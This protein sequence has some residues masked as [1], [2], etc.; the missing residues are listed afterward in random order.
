MSEPKVLSD[1]D[2]VRMLRSDDGAEVTKALDELYGPKSAVL[3]VAEVGGQAT[4]YPTKTVNLPAMFA[5]LVFAAGRFGNAMGLGLDWTEKTKG[6][7]IVIAGPNHV[8]GA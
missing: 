5:G 4:Y 3:V 1:A 7:G 2:L 6:P 8:P